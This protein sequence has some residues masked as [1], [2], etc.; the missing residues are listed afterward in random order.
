[1]GTV[2]YLTHPS[3]IVRAIRD[4]RK[5]PCV[6]V[7]AGISFPSR[8]PTAS[9]FLNALFGSL[10]IHEE[11]QNELV[12]A[13]S[14]GWAHGISFHDYLRFEQ[15]VAVLKSTIDPDLSALKIFDTPVE[16]NYYHYQIATLIRHGS[17]VMTTTL[18]A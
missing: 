18:T 9:H 16:P 6:L 11:F 8:L 12:S 7:G 3:D 5:P 1:M 17:L 4:L 2:T 15:V 14:S 10:P 13:C